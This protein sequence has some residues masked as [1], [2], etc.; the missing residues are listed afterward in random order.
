MNLWACGMSNE[1]WKPWTSNSGAIDVCAGGHK[2]KVGMMQAN[3]QFLQIKV[4]LFEVSVLRTF[5]H[6]S[7]ASNFALWRPRFPLPTASKT[8]YS[9]S[10]LISV[11]WE[12]W[13]HRSVERIQQK[14]FSTFIS[15]LPHSNSLIGHMTLETQRKTKAIAGRKWIN[16]QELLHFYQELLSPRNKLV[17]QYILLLI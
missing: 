16:N 11:L 1:E 15:H 14:T 7:Y 8:H 4:S 3:W 13:T 2:S 6:L 12:L 10:K 5:K 17:P 9:L